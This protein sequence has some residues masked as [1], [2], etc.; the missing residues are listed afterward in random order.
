MG[1][2]YETGTTCRSAKKKLGFVDGLIPKLEDDNNKEEEQWTLNIMVGSWILNT[3]EPSIKQIITYSERC[4][5]L[6]AE[7]KDF[8]LKRMVVNKMR[9]WLPY[10]IVNRLD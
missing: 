5:E 3:I 6:W 1:K 10:A 4:D 8:S 2:S 9:L 7:L